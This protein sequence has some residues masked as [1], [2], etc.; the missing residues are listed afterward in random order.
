MRIKHFLS[1]L[2]LAHIVLFSACKPNE[3]YKTVTTPQGQKL[4]Y[5]DPYT[6]DAGRNLLKD[7][8]PTNPD[9]TVNVVVEIP[10]GTNQKWE[11]SKPDGQLKWEIKNGK[12]RVVKYVGYP[13]NYGMIPR[14]L[15]PKS[16]GGDGDPLDVLV[17][18]PAVPRGS[19]VKA[20]IIGVLRLLD[21]GEQDDKLIAVLANS[22]LQNVNSIKQLDEQYHGITTIINAWFENYKGPGKLKSNGFAEADVALTI[23]NQSIKAFK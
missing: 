1:I 9:G 15:L 13:G 5:L 14:T 10:T 19:V 17:L 4:T 2:L 23:L 11:V 20:K 12:P 7:I 18:G 22:P 6:I 8:E 16:Q 21:G 3:P